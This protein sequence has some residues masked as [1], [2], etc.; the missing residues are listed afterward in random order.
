MKGQASVQIALVSASPTLAQAR[1]TVGSAFDAAP[2]CAVHVLDLDGSYVPLR[3]EQVVTPRDLGVETRE[4]HVRAILLDP[5]DLVRWTQPA[6]VRHALRAAPTVLTVSAGVLLLQD[7]SELTDLAD[8]HQVALIA[9]CA[10]AL[11]ADG[12][13]PGPVDLLAAG[14]YT[15][16][17]LAVSRRATA[18]L[19]LWEQL[20]ADPRTASGRWLDVAASHLAHHTVHG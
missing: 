13:C 5:I 7:P 19:D 2:A 17:L 18:F 14:S 11:P 16:H 12:T 8:Q 3:D 1:A 4:L 20:A 9:R 10:E 6:L 15:P